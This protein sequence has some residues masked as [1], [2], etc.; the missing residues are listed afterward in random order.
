MKKKNFLYFIFISGFSKFL[1]EMFI[2]IILYKNNISLDNIILFLVTRSVFSLILLYP[3]Y[4]LITKIN[5]KS[6]L[7]LSIIPFILSY[8]YLINYNM[9]LLSFFSAL[10]THLYFISRNI[11]VYNN[12]KNDTKI[13][14]LPIKMVI[15]ITISNVTGVFI[16]S[17]LL[18][19]LNWN[20]VL[21]ISTILFIISIYYTYNINGLKEEK[22]DY[23]VIYDKT[24]K[25]LKTFYFFEQFKFA[26]V[27]LFP[28]YIY[29]NVNQTF[30]TIGYFSVLVGLTSI[31]CLKILNKDIDKNNKDYLLLF[32]LL[33]CGILILKLEITNLSTFLV[34]AL[35]EGIVSRIYDTIAIS[36]S[37]ELE[38]KYNNIL[39]FE[40]YYNI[41]RI[42][43]FLVCLN[44]NNFK[45]LIYF[46]IVG[47]FTSS[48]IK[49]KDY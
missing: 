3:I 31:F 36:K 13:I 8:I 47:L 45:L 20:Y 11:I 41:G 37:Y 18:E 44:I 46:L 6:S 23:K 26:L 28:L 9:I 30:T 38:K 15:L 43:I 49:K 21:V 39:I 42:I 7:Y 33:F 35:L 4:K 16:G 2:P 24:N 12:L 10:A 14:N 25:H 29:I 32:T 5:I 17:Y 48:L 22:I 1:I 34:I 40:T 27:T 19:F